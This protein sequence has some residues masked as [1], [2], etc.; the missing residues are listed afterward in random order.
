MSDNNSDP[1]LIDRI[2]ESK[3]ASIRKMV[4]GAAFIVPTVA[5]F[6]L[7]G[8]AINEAHAAIYCSNCTF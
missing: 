1:K 8:L 6:S 7:N 5:S 3:R 4:L 2:D